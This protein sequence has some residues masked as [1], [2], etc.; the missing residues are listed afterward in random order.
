M[1]PRHI[2]ERKAWQK[3]EQTQQRAAEKNHVWR[4]AEHLSTGLWQ[5]GIICVQKVHVCLQK[6]EP[7]RKIQPQFQKCELKPKS[8]I[9]KSQK[10]IF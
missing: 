10:S 4:K 1:N 9:F 7:Q 5:T 2:K 3:V 8:V 6:P